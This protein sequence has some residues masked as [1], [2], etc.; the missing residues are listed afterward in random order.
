SSFDAALMLDLS[1]AGIFQ[2]LDRKSFLAD[3]K[4]GLTAESIRFS[5]WADG[6]AE[7]L[8]KTQLT[9]QGETLRGELRPFGVGTGREDLRTTHEVPVKESRRLA[10]FFADALF[11][12]LTREPGP[13]QTHLAYVRKNGANREVWLSDWDG[14]H[15][16]AIVK[17]GLNVLPAL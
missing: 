5:R 10:H 17:D 16:Q 8:V 7:A 15:A 14:N 1:A 4:E 12:S 9:V 6:G 13:F 11:K 2:V 3:S